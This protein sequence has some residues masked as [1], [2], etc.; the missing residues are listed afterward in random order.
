MADRR[1]LF[2][3]DD[4]GEG[5]QRYLHEQ[6]YPWLQGGKQGTLPPWD[7][8]KVFGDL[9]K[10]KKRGYN[11][12]S[13]AQDALF[14][15]ILMQLLKGD[16]RAEQRFENYVAPVPNVDPT[17]EDARRNSGFSGVVYGQ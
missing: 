2:S 15:Q 13:N 11:L 9:E 6:Y 4:Y 1:R 7:Q 14:R 12:T 3:G 16:P 8:Y 5:R 17:L 10:D